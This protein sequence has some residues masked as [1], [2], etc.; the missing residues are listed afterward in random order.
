[1]WQRCLDDP[2]WRVDVRL[3]CSVEI[4]R[5]DVENRGACLL[6]T[7]IVDPDVQAAETLHGASDKV[8]TE[9]LVSQTAGD[10]ET[11]ASVGLDQRDDFLRVRLFGRKIVD[12]DIGAFPGI[13]DRRRSA[14]AGV[15]PGNKSLATGEPS[16]PFIAGFAVVRPWIHFA[17]E[18]R[19][20]LRLLLVRRLGI[21]VG[22]ILKCL[23][24]HRLIS[25]RQA[26]FRFAKGAN[27][28]RCKKYPRAMRLVPRIS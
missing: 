26:K 4:F 2:E 24:A 16:G 1:M 25:F 3:H 12:R 7:S 11:D 9:F 14:H 23:L 15:S 27:S 20:R 6:P 21:F 28:A 17:C 10:R 18:P 8:L 5:G 19:P 13:S 22:R